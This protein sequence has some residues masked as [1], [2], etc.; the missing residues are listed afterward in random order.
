[1]F[2]FSCSV[3]SDSATPESIACQV[4]L[5]MGFSR[6]EY[7]S[8][9]PFPSPEDLPNPGDEPSC[10][11]LQ[12]DSLPSEPPGKPTNNRIIIIILATGKSSP[13]MRQFIHYLM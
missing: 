3:V 10:P 4:P 1:M 8:G 12:V 5:S 13:Y 7:W 2:C 11:S 6:Q 9:L